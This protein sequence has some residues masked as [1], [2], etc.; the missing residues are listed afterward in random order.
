MT[1]E[2]FI[3]LMGLQDNVPLAKIMYQV[4]TSSGLSFDDW[5]N[6]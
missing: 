3:E 2:H 5:Y 6:N 4:F 1:L